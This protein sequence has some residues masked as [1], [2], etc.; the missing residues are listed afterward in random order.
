MI[1]EMDALSTENEILAWQIEAISNGV[2]FATANCWRSARILS[3][4]KA[5]FRSSP[6]RVYRTVSTI[7]LMLGP[8]NES[9]KVNEAI[10]YDGSVRHNPFFASR[11]S[12]TRSTHAPFA[13][14]FRDNDRQWRTIRKENEIRKNAF[15]TI[16]CVVFRG[17]VRSTDV[18]PRRG[19]EL[20]QISVK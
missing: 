20:P 19:L 8:Y 15:R 9:K 10:T 16:A 12:K 18:V 14:H 5:Q 7:A 1:L 4:K 13:L 2:L 3:F 11:S 6:K 17:L